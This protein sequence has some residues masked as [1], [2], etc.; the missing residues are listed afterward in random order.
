MNSKEIFRIENLTTGYNGRH[1]L[2]GANLSL[3][4]GEICCIVGE[5]GS[6]KSTLLKAITRHLKS[7]GNIIWNGIDLINI[8]TSKMTV[9]S[10]DFI[11][12]GGNILPGFTVEEHICLALSEKSDTK[13]GILWQEVEK[14][15]PKM[16][17]LKKQ[18]AGR[19]SG[20]ERII[21]SIACV[22]ATDADFLVLDEPTAGL[23]PETC[24]VI[25]NFLVRI[26][27]ERNKTVLIFEHNYDFAFEIADT[28]V[29]LKE[30]KLSEKYFGDV[31][32]EP[33]FIDVKLYGS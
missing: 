9:N 20:G 22:M 14:T 7:T 8:P 11:A 29:T 33:N 16:A 13:K 19:L 1:I 6:G 3:R 4:K 28:V 10:V 24:K 25:E 23:A 2:Q 18:V 5:E 26:K 21:L 17:T 15:F 32:K 30:G 12:Q 27:N 31:F